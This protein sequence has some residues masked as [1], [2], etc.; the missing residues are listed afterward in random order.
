MGRGVLVEGDDLVLVDVEGVEELLDVPAPRG[1]YLPGERVP[2]HRDLLEEFHEVRELD[3]PAALSQDQPPEPRL[4]Q[5]AA[6]QDHPQVARVVRLRDEPVAVA[7][8]Q[9]EDAADEGVL[10]AQ[11]PEPSPEL[12]VVHAALLAELVEAL[13]DHLALLLVELGPAGLLLFVRLLVPQQLP[14]AL[15]DHL[16][17]LQLL[18]LRLA[19]HRIIILEAAAG[20]RLLWSAAYNIRV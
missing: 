8:D 11:Q 1:H 13:R 14:E 18:L 9:V 4:L 12:L 7:V 5:L 15:V 10:A 19:I 20:R 3:V 17:L 2:H 6:P 16:G